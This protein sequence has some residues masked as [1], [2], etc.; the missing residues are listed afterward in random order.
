MD[1]FDKYERKINYL[2]RFYPFREK[3]EKIIKAQN[4]C[5]NFIRTN[6]FHNGPYD[7]TLYCDEEDFFEFLKTLPREFVGPYKQYFFNG[8]SDP[9]VKN[10][11][12][13]LKFFMENFR[14][15]LQ[16]PNTFFNQRSIDEF[17]LFYIYC[18]DLFCDTSFYHYI[19]NAMRA[20]ECDIFDFFLQTFEIQTPEFEEKFGKY[21]SELSH[22]SQRFRRPMIDIFTRIINFLPGMLGHVKNWKVNCDFESFKFLTYY[23]YG[24]KVNLIRFIGEEDFLIEKKEIIDLNGFVMN[25]W[26]NFE[27]VFAFGW[28]EN[29]IILTM[30]NDDYYPSPEILENIS[31]F[32]RDDVLMRRKKNR[33]YYDADFESVR[34]FLDKYEESKRITFFETIFNY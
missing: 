23:N 22:I 1:D 21:F 24:C 26:K 10:K 11:E 15:N 25:T 7:I 30:L 19:Y 5:K 20:G 6:G 8:F 4:F 17:K 16:I 14:E 18:Q 12:E 33:I 13:Y 29:L 2:K 32:N 34:N 3:T 28:N 9:I 31:V 27:N